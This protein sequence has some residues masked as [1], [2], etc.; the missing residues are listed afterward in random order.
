MGGTLNKVNQDPTFE[1][2]GVSH[3][4]E[5]LESCTD[6]ELVKPQKRKGA[7]GDFSDSEDDES[8]RAHERKKFKGKSMA[9][10]KKLLQELEM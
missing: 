6:M 10:T 4:N 2:T 5:V 8:E 3:G 9:E 1:G 7:F